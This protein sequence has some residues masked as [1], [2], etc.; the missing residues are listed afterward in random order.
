MVE[1]WKSILSKENQVLLEEIQQQLHSLGKNSKVYPLADDRYRAFDLVE[2][3]NVQVVILGQDPY[4]GQGQ[5]N[6]L[7]FSV[8]PGMPL[9]PS[10]KNIFGE[11]E[12]DLGVCRF[13]SDLSD[14]AKQGVLLL[15]SMLTV[16]EA[17]PGS[18]E[19]LGWEKLTDNWIE[20]VSNLNQNTVFILWGAF[21]Q[22]KESFINKEKGHLVLKSAHPSPLSS[23]RGFFGSKPFSKTNTFLKEHNKEEIQWQD[24]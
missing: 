10:L 9:P 20:A 11:L 16:E 19:Y 21:A 23:Y 7:C 6:G 22:K 4:H 24:N 12:S 14:W 3:N 5:A 15:N 8:N 18:H 13:S 17:K 2:P 1:V